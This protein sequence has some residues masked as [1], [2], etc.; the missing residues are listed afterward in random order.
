ML[1]EETL[2]ATLL[3]LFVAGI[4]TTSTTLSYTLL[5]LAMYPEV[6]DK[7]HQEITNAIGKNT[8]TLGDRKS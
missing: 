1:T 8:V 5:Y 7:V 6:Q 4:E 2:V 3:D